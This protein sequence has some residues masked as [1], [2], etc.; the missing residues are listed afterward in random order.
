MTNIEK[1][2]KKIISFEESN[3]FSCIAYS[4]D[5][6]HIASF[7]P[8]GGGNVEDDYYII[9]I[10]DT[11]T[12]KLFRTIIERTSYTRNLAF[13][14]NKNYLVYINFNLDKNE[15]IYNIKIIDYFSGNEIISLQNYNPQ[16]IACSPDGQRLA[17]INK[18]ISLSESLFDIHTI[19]VLDTSTWNEIKKYDFVNIANFDS[20]TYS[21]NSQYLYFTDSNNLIIDTFTDKKVFISN[22]FDTLPGSRIALS[23]DLKLI[24]SSYQGELDT[25][26]INI[27]GFNSGKL[28]KTVNDEPIYGDPI[29]YPFYCMSF[30]IDNE[31]IVAI[32]EGNLKVFEIK[33]GKIIKRLASGEIFAFSPNGKYIAMES[34]GS[35]NEL[36]IFEFN[37]D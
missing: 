5:G 18:E 9:K 20:L 13:I 16:Y 35:G 30:S 36:S 26:D 7:V 29:N 27:W 4:S 21:E 22:E 8:S 17:F 31:Y 15:R 28:L 14:K 24:A 32:I 34:V 37:F 1:C 10:W 12:G 3:Y 23:S 6:R 11:T 33:S 19:R 2:F 25:E